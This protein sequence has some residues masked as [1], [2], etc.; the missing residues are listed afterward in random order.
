M[1]E[2]KIT[3]VWLIHY[4]VPYKKTNETSRPFIIIENLNDKF[5]GIPLTSFFI[6][7]Y[8]EQLG[9]MIIDKPF[10]FKKSIIK[11]YQITQLK[12]KFFI[13]K[14]GVVESQIVKDINHTIDTNSK[15]YLAIKNSNAILREYVIER[16]NQRIEA[17]KQEINN[18]KNELIIIKEQL[19]LIQ[20]DRELL[21]E[22][23]NN[24]IKNLELKLESLQQQLTLTQ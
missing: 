19:I 15:Q 6:H 23:A 10:L 18:I 7:R 5:Y 17:L 1:L 3:D 20:K 8:K 22:T 13:K 12:E 16:Q 14:V 24:L 2:I 4:P 11:P 21:F 9:D